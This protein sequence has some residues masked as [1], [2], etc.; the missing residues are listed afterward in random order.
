MQ[1][2][3]GTDPT[4]STDLLAPPLQ[5]TDE[6]DAGNQSTK[7]VSMLVRCSHRSR[8]SETETCQTELIPVCGFKSLD[9][10]SFFYRYSF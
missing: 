3:T 2:V 7:G 5:P 8:K 9:M 4:N 6:A 10:A 1:K